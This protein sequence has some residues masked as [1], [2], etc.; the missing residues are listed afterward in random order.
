[1]GLIELQQMEV[2]ALVIPSQILLFVILF[3]QSQHVL[4]NNEF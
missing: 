3:Y 1:M 2:F 4:C